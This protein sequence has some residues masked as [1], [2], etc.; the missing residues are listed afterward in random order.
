MRTTGSPSEIVKDPSAIKN[1]V[2]DPTGPRYGRPSD[3]F[4]PSTALFSPELALLKYDLEHLEA[5]A[6][7]S[8]DVDHAFDLIENAASSFDEE[9]EREAGLR[10]ILGG[11]LVGKRQ[12]QVPIAD[13]MTKSYGVR[14]GKSLAYLIVEAKNELGSGGDPFLQGLLTYSKILAQDQVPFP[15]CPLLHF[16]KMPQTVSPIPQAIKPT[17]CPARHSGEPPHR[18]DCHF[19]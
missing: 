17:G 11:L 14:L 16:T 15:L 19:H 10:S 9:G 2:E 6:P 4:G 5:F 3:R 12:W 8:A 7:N 13:G 18:V 1:A